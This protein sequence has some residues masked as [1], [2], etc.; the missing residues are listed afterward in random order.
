VTFELGQELVNPKRRRGGSSMIVMTLVAMSV[1]LGAAAAT[2][3]ENDAQGAAYVGASAFG[4]AALVALFGMLKSAPRIVYGAAAFGSF[5]F[6]LAIVLGAPSVLAAT[7]SA[8]PLV[9]AVPALRSTR[10]LVV[11]DIRLPSLTYYADRVPEWVAGD[12]LG[13]RLDRGDAPFV[14]IADVDLDRLPK[15]V[16]KRLREVAHSGK[17]FVF[18]PVRAAP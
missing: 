4:L 15:D 6:L 1:G 14:V 7:R 2:S 3:L 8:A 9:D 18:E 17:L 11:V 10:P 5:S 16:R 12:N 13:A